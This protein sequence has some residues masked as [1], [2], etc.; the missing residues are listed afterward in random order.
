MTITGTTRECLQHLSP[1]L[2]IN[3][4]RLLATAVQVRESAIRTWIKGSSQPVGEPLMRLR[5]YLTHLGYHVTE[6]DSVDQTLQELANLIA[7]AVVTRQEAV[8][9]IGARSRGENQ[10]YRYLGGTVKCS[11]E[12]LKALRELLDSKK[13]YTLQ[14]P[15]LKTFVGSPIRAYQNP[16]ANSNKE[17]FLI[18][19]MVSL[20]EAMSPVAERLL[21]DEF[22]AVH[23]D[24]LRTITHGAIPQLSRSLDRLSDESAQVLCRQPGSSIATSS[25]AKLFQEEPEAGNLV[26][27][28]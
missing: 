12:R 11:P 21:S 23:R 22:T 13:P 2:D 9:T 19:T 4:R 20:I 3:N 24:N 14:W 26:R 17:Q 18:A 6:W 16:C 25:R 27:E 1:I 15:R 7:C 10:L 5:A 8:T 28:P